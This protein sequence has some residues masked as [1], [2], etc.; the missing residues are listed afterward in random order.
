MRPLRSNV[1]RAAIG[2]ILGASLLAA[3]SLAAPLPVQGSDDCTS[4]Q[5]IT[6]TG[7]YFFDNAAATI[8]GVDNGCDMARDVWFRWT[9]PTSA[10]YTVSTCGATTIDSAL[11]VYL[12]AACPNGS[13]L[14]CGDDQCGLQSELVFG[15]TAGQSYLLRVGTWRFAQLGGSGTL[16][17]LEEGSLGGC[18][19]PSAGPNVVAGDLGEAIVYGDVA[20]TS[21][22]SMATT[23]CNLGD[24]ELLWIM[25]NDVHPVVGHNLYRLENGRFEQLGASWVKHG[26]GALQRDLCCDCIPSATIEALGVGCSDPYGAVLNGTQP[27]L[28]PRGEIDPFSG[29]FSWPPGANTGVSPASG[30]LDRRLQ[31]P[32]EAMDPGLHPTAVYLAEAV[33]AAP[34][35]AA[36][37]NG[38]DNASSRTYRRTGAVVQGG[39]VIEPEGV[40]ERARPAVAAWA[41]MDP[42]VRLAE[43]TS[44]APQFDVIT[45]TVRAKQTRL[46]LPSVSAP[47]SRI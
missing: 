26:I 22:Y 12:D 20:G 21:A 38:F 28:G 4:A 46:P 34:D 32:T 29:T 13:P 14:A 31:V 41:A 1:A 30:A 25:G 8:D 16:S 19:D 5:T 9:A 18:V 7:Q 43:V 27:G 2:A 6:G 36:A 17:I 24:E 47:S 44:S 33:F 10:V 11:A 3:P 39:F 35:D 45:M 15:T 37:G 23:A 40:T 42:T